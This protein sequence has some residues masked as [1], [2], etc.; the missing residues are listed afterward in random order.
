MGIGNIPISRIYK[1]THNTYWDYY[2]SVHSGDG[3]AGGQWARTATVTFDGDLFEGTLTNVAPNTGGED[4]LWEADKAS[5]SALSFRAAALNG[6]DVEMRAKGE[7]MFHFN[8]NNYDTTDKRW[9][10]IQGLL[11]KLSHASVA[12][13][14]DSE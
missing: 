9:E 3:T 12:Y 14:T 10:K 2:A 1:A 7:E 5:I 13:L 6:D 8:F 4:F 11:F